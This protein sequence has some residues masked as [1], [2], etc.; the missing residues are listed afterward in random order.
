MIFSKFSN[1]LVL[2]YNHYP[3]KESS[4]SHTSISSTC[5]QATS[6]LLS[7]LTDFPFLDISYQ[8]NH[9]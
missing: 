1:I 5:P 4:C 2:N 6:H 3:E 9:E 7:V 8:W